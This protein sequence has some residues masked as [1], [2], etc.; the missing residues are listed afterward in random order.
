MG[1]SYRTSS[2]IIVL[3]QGTWDE[4]LT[5]L[6]PFA[7]TPN[8]VW[9][10]CPL[11][12][13][14]ARRRKG[15]VA[16]RWGGRATPIGPPWTRGRWHSTT[17]ATHTLFPQK[18]ADTMTRH[19]GPVGHSGHIFL[20]PHAHTMVRSV[21]RDTSYCGH[22]PGDT[23]A[24]YSGNL[25]LW[26]HLNNRAFI[27]TL[28]SFLADYIHA[29]SPSCYLLHHFHFMPIDFRCTRFPSVC[30][31]P[32]AKAFYLKLLKIK[33]PLSFI[34][35]SSLLVMPSERNFPSRNSAHGFV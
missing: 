13:P 4:H 25:L 35:P 6:C 24:P 32:N 2:H 5:L 14:C 12:W 28:L 16:S 9:C 33:F 11:S 34:M 17:R 7:D 21:I 22:R 3:T 15:S 26:P 27:A 19:D 31:S 18:P 8:P 23:S 30:R 1:I 29:F 20:R 10:V